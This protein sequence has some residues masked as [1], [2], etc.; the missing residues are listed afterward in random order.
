MREELANS[1]DGETSPRRVGRQTEADAR[2]AGPLQLRH[3]QHGVGRGD[4]N[5][6]GFRRHRRDV[7]AKGVEVRR[8]G[9]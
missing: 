4:E 6:N 8:A 2:D 5:V 1:A 3:G 7:A 9:L